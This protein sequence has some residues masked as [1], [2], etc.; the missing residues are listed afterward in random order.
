MR[1]IKITLC[2][3]FFTALTNCGF[4]VVNQSDLNNFDIIEI[5][6]T[7]DKRIGYKIKNK[8]IFN[9][10]KDQKKALVITLD[11][12]KNKTIKEKNIKNEIKKYKIELNIIVKVRNITNGKII[13]FSKTKTGDYLVANQY[14]QTLKNEKKLIISLSDNIADDILKELINRSNDL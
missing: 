6:T 10:N 4:K 9:S 12:N 8:L 2:L 3:V 1:I 13:N 11:T 5:T 14:S 7:G